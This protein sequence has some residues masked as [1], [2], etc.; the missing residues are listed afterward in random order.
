MN[1]A[2]IDIMFF[3]NI[4]E[5]TKFVDDQIRD[6]E[7]KLSQI[8]GIIEQL[9]DRVSRYETF[10]KMIE[11]L[12]GK[13]QMPISTTIEITGLKILFDPRP[14]DEYEVLN[15]AYSAISDRL[16]VLRRI[17]EVLNVLERY[18]SDERLNI[19]VEFRAG[20]PIKIVLKS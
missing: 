4:R 9:R 13:E 20:I 11:E 5:F 7:R 16:N 3:K 18:L 8:S 10:R 17:R 1:T 2:D 12:T 19:I 6:L 15:K 14:I